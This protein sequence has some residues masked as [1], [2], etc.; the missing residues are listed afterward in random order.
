[1]IDLRTHGDGIIRE[2]NVMVRKKAQKIHNTKNR[3]NN[4]LN[5]GDT[6]LIF[7]VFL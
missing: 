7:C 2:T 5:F 4:I 6:E 3:K 1:M